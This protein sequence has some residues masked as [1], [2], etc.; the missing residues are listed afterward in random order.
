MVVKLTNQPNTV[1]APLDT[2]MKVKREK[3]DCPYTRSARGPMYLNQTKTHTKSDRNQ[4]ETALRE[5]AEDLGGLATDGKTE[6][7]TRRTVQE[8][9]AGG[10]GTSD[11]RGVDYVWEDLDAGSAHSDDVWT[12]RREY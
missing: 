12:E 8:T 3:S 11:D 10:E 9:I 5:S 4:W 2:V 6:Q 7:D 1:A